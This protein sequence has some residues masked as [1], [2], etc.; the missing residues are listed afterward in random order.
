MDILVSH[1]T[2]KRSGDVARRDVEIETDVVRLGRGSD[3]QVH[4]HDPRVAYIH[5]EIH[6]RGGSFFIEAMNASFELLVNGAP[7]NT[8]QLKIGD[9]IIIGPYEIVVIDAPSGKSLA[10]SIELLEKRLDHLERLK[11]LSHTTLAD[12]DASMRGM[13]WAFFIV[14]FSLFL[15][16]PLV[17]FFVLSDSAT[18][19][20]SPMQTSDGG[21]KIWPMTPD[22]AWISGDISAPHRFVANDC[23]VCHQRAFVQVE[24]QACLACHSS[25]QQ[26]ADPVKFP[27]EQISGAACQSCHKEHNGAAA[28][29]TVSETQ[30]ADCHRNLK[31]VAPQATL[32]NTSNFGTD[33]PQ[34]RPTVVVNAT[35][36]E[37]KRQKLD[38]DNWPVEN[39]NLK[40]THKKHLA[41]AGVLVPGKT[42]RKV[43]QCA[44]C[45]RPEP[46]GVGMQP[47]TM[48]THCAECHQ[49]K[50]EPAVPSRVVPHGD[51]ASV[52]LTVTEFYGN[53]ALRGGA[54]I[55][56]APDSV[57]RRPGSEL[58]E[59]ERLEALAWADQRTALAVDYLFGKSVCRVCHEVSAVQQGASTSW[60]IENILITDRWLPK[61]R[62]DHGHHRNMTCVDCHEATDSKK[63]SDVL[64]PQVA[65]CQQCH[66]GETAS[67]LVPTTCNSCHEF[68]QP[69]LGSMRPMQA[70]ANGEGG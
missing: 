26:H 46:G 15:V 68:H 63:A 19:T 67:N 14:V 16:W 44:D 7:V 8:T 48:Q 22:L 43:L 38:R 61:G 24:D 52:M 34:F 23:K 18:S 70:A 17:H 39:S 32:V 42:E 65:N 59:T 57:R 62:F 40:F 29:V 6:D 21:A 41:A 37:H 58:T 55:A 25:V 5:A 35:T 33:H 54:D 51:V 60:S 56:D 49:L 30:C 53:M 31:D 28:I 27:L 64:L 11:S 1:L 10:F 12:A 66:G 13:S 45:H 69:F 3:C 50:F 9:K 20:Q 47:I 36:G 4:L 2:R